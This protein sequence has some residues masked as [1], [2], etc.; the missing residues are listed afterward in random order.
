MS[1][2]KLKLFRAKKIITMDKNR[3]TA[4]HVAVLDGKILSV[5][6]ASLE[7]EWENAELDSQFS[8]C[9]LMPGFVEGHAHM[10]AGG[11]WSYSYVGYHQRK[12]PD[13]KTWAALTS[14]EEVL[15][16]LHEADGELATGEP[17]IAWGFDPIFMSTE[18]LN[19]HHLDKVSTSRPIAIIHSNFHLM[20]VNSPTLALAGFSRDS[21]A[22]GMARDDN[23]EPNGELREMAAMFPVM[24]RLGI[25]FSELAKKEEG[26]RAY[27]RTASH[28]GVTTAA[29]LFSDLTEGELETMLAITGEEDFQLRIVPALNA[30]TDN[31]D[32]I[33]KRALSLASRSTDRLRLGIV[34]IMT[35]G[36]IQGYTARIKWPGYITGHPNGIWNTPPEQLFK[37][38]ETVHKAGVQMHIHVNGDE[39]SEVTL[40]ALEAAMML[41]PR[42]DHRHTL[43][44]CQMADEAQ[45][46]RMSALGLCVNLFANHIW[47]FGDQ[48]HDLTIGPDRA[49]RM[50][51]CRSA[52]DHGVPL[53]IHSDAPVT[54]MAPLFTAWCAVNRFTPSGR[55]LGRAQQLTVEKALHAITLGAAYTLRL[56]GEIGSIEV[57]KKADFAVLGEDPLVV[58]PAELKDVEVLGTV[59]N[60]RIF[61]Q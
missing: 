54:P 24:R 52:N 50:D 23:G 29:D 61:V 10:M 2:S 36:A 26:I 8:D 34:K 40:D 46:K 58:N 59:Q 1:D 53:A 12:D 55:V 47:Y 11:I 30:M 48:H 44:H 43:Q 25:D 27:G 33:A 22:E 49:M 5:G 17:L 28:V 60:G 7:D 16:R 32:A 51:A 38:V 14:V 13:G 4:T 15:D 31:P 56:D 35:D 41:H 3:P 19:C 42:G 57:G 21:A 37:M 20:T 9:V 6:D 39:A 18:R 45:F